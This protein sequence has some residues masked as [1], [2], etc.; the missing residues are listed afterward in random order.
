MEFVALA[1]VP[2][3]RVSSFEFMLWPH[4]FI[5]IASCVGLLAG[6][7]IIRFT[8]KTVVEE[9]GTGTFEAAQVA[10]GAIDLALAELAEDL[11]K[12][13]ESAGR[14]QIIMERLGE[15]QTGAI[16]AFV[17]CRPALVKVLGLSG[18]AELMDRFAALE[19]QINRAWSAAADGHE[20]EAADCLAKTV[21]LLTDTANKLKRG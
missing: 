16:P 19:R 2:H 13:P 4:K 15:L 20:E 8:G 3:V 11:P 7:G 10:F 14:L 5:F 9:G 21:D 12:M 18:Y 6:A 1:G 17:D